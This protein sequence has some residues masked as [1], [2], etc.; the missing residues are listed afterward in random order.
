M[1]TFANPLKILLIIHL[2]PQ[3]VGL[4]TVVLLINP[5]LSV[6]SIELS[7]GVNL[8]HS[9]ILNLITLTNQLP[10]VSHML[11]SVWSCVTQNIILIDTLLSVMHM[12]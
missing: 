7:V 8:R 4:V 1:P 11:L 6:G 5:L 12:L 2:K 9:K 10:L 3:R